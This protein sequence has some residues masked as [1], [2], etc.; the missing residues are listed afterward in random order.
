MGLS[1]QE[2]EELL[3]DLTAN[4]MLALENKYHMHLKTIEVA[5]SAHYEFMTWVLMHI[6]NNVGVD[7]EDV[8]FGEKK[9]DH[10]MARHIFFYLVRKY[11]QKKIYYGEICAYLNRDHQ[12][13]SQSIIR[14]V[15]LLE[16]SKAFR[17]TVMQ[18]EN[19]MN[20]D[21][22]RVV[23]D[24]LGGEVDV[25]NVPIGVQFNNED[26]ITLKT[27]SNEQEKNTKF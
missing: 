27:K 2:R 22:E 20:K 7:P 6:C 11:A 25:P 15:K 18:I 23:F 5:K 9:L 8:R 13:M 1:P 14:V 21:F 24:F 12:S 16:K 4:V 26:E 10:N 17:T 3:A 19:D